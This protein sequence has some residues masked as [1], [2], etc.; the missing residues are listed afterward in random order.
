MWGPHAEALYEIGGAEDLIMNAVAPP[1]KVAILYASST[2]IWQ[3]SS[4]DGNYAYGFD[5]MHTWM[6][7]AHAQIPVDFLSEAQV[8]RGALASYR[9]CYLHGPNLTRAAAAKLDAWVNAGGTLVATAGAGARDEYNRTFATIES[10][11]PATRGTLSTLQR[12]VNSG[13]YLNILNIKDT[14]TAGAAKINV[15]SVR[16]PLTAKSGTT[17][18]GKFNDNT[19]AWVYGTKGSGK[20]HCLGFLPALDYIRE[21][22]VLRKD[23]AGKPLDSVSGEDRWRLEQSANP[24]AYPA[25][26]REAILA[27]VREA[28]IDPPVICSV[29]QVDAVYMRASGDV[30]IPLANYTL[31]P[32]DTVHFSV[33]VD[34]TVAYVETIYQGR[35]PFQ[36]KGNRVSF[37]VPLAS[38]DYVKIYYKRGLMLIL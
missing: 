27:P 16:Q 32:L 4:I 22:L 19:P 10:L 21:A 7:L 31:Y 5:R 37:S 38:T 1:A 29:P 35:I 3:L 28:A 20:V 23:L 15:L 12:F 17:T 9:V 26:V 2:D 34:R 18:R 8:E 30:V 36:Q 25:A 33:R 11:L 6:A 14:V 13:S 24:W